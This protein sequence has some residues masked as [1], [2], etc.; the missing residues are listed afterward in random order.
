MDFTDIL[1]AIDGMDRHQMNLATLL[2]RLQYNVPGINVI[3]RTMY[4]QLADPA[5]DRQPWE[6]LCP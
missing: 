3:Y 6:L 4:L 5:H 2:D 1:G